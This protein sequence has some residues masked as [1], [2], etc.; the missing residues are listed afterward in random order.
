[1]SR[2]DWS[3]LDQLT[4]YV[5]YTKSKTLAERAAWQFV[6]ENPSLQLVTINPM[7]VLG[8][9]L[10]EEISTSNMLISKLLQGEMPALPNLHFEMVDVRDVALAHFRAMTLPGAVGHRYLCWSANMHISQV[11]NILSQRYSS[12]VCCVAW[13]RC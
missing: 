10:T 4:E 6:S 9:V 8:P 1:M 7:L 3:R 2:E 5:A 12:Q 11:A 13:Q